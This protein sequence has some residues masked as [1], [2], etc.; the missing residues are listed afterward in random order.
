M[1]GLFRFAMPILVSSCLILPGC[2]DDGDAKTV[3]ALDFC[4]HIA[5]HEII[6][7]SNNVGIFP[8]YLVQL[9]PDSLEDKKKDLVEDEEERAALYAQALLDYEH[10]P[11]ILLL[12]EIWSVKARD[13]LIS[14]LASKYPYA[15]YPD[16][17]GDDALQ[18][19]GLMVFSKYALHDFQYH[20]FTAG[21]GV[22]L[23][24]MKGIIGVRLVKDDR[25]IAAF[26]T[27]L[28]AGAKDPTTKP[29]QLRE[30]LEFMDGFTGDDEA[31]VKIF[32]GD[33]NTSSNGDHYPEIFDIL[34]GAVDSYRPGCSELE[35][36]A[37]YDDDPTKRIDYLLTFDGIEAVSTIDDPGGP[38]LA[39][40]YAV[41]G[42]VSL[43]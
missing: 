1:K 26:V 13:V 31:T 30:C 36:T 42:R 18:P 41:L 14:A 33:L 23:L 34:E 11:D 16:A 27:H 43:E 24:S 29:S 9:Y 3:E 2:V 12:Q 17:I 7:Y 37:R 22:D 38:T 25:N 15:E 39:D 10:D 4:E 40:H 35:T 32:V 19:S 8:D 5:E 21:E 28:Q 6:V 20:V